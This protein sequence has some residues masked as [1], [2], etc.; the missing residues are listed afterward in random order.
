MFLSVKPF[1]HPTFDDCA[2]AAL[3][4]QQ[5]EPRQAR[6]CEQCHCLAVFTRAA[7]ECLNPGIRVQ[8]SSFFPLL[9]LKS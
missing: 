9:K 3:L 6:H 5:S 2:F 7:P 4:L 1:H 8:R